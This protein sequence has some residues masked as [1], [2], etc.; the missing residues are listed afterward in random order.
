MNFYNIFGVQYSRPREWV[1]CL[2]NNLY[3]INNSGLT[4]FEKTKAD[5]QVRGCVQYKVDTYVWYREEIVI[6][7]YMDG[8]LVFIT[9]KDKLY[10]VYASIQ[11]ELKIEVDGELNKR[12]LLSH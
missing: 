1:I 9:S 12:T 5:L 8:F 7:F 10:V 2:G 11:T 3:G 6:L 4:S